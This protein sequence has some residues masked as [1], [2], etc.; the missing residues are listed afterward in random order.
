MKLTGTYDEDLL[1]E[2]K[3]QQEQRI[4]NAV[5]VP[6]YESRDQFVDEVRELLR[7][8]R[9][10]WETYGPESPAADDPLSE[11]PTRWLEQVRRVLIPNNWRIA[12]LMEINRRHLTDEEREVG[13][14]FK[15]HAEV[16][17]EQ[18]LS[19]EPDPDAPRFP[20]EMDEIFGPV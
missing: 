19:G 7:E 16:F 9:T 3:R 13:A 17:A 12:R 11:A 4:R 15:L 1:R 8:N 2:W 14:R 6:E 5:D 10:W 18:H 20:A